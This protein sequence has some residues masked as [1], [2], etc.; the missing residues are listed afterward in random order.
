MI[1]MYVQ[2]DW[3]VSDRLT[4]NLGLRY[5]YA[6]DIMAN[7]IDWTGLRAPQFA[8]DPI[9]TGAPNQFNMLQP[10]AGFAYALNENETVVRGG[11]GLYFTGVNDVS[12]IHTEFPLS[13]LSVANPNDGRPDFPSNPWGNFPEGRQPTHEE[14]IAGSQAGLYRLDLST[15]G[16]VTLDDARVPYSH[17]F[18]LGFQQQIGDTMAFQADYVYQGGRGFRYPRNENLT[19]DAATGLNRPYSNPANRLWPDVGLVRIFDHAKTVNYHGVEM[20]F[21]KRFS[22][23]YQLSGTYTVG[24]S[25]SCSPSPVDDAFPVARDLGDD[26]W[27]TSHSDGGPADQR[28]RAVINGIWELP[29]DFQLSGLYHFGSGQRFDSFNPVDLRDT[30]GFFWPWPASAQRLMFDGSII[31]HANVEGEAIHRVDMKVMRRFNIGDVSIDGM[32]EVFNLFN[33]Q[34]YGFYQRVAILPSAGDPLPSADLA[35]WPR[36]VQLGFKVGF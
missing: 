6:H 31:D 32:V 2:D 36:M 34:N 20:G 29:Y 21:S 9:R 28:H 24:R 14:V 1:S 5:D 7:D 30:G 27:Y 13:F 25:R 17:Q 3:Q 23:G 12:A 33:H 15:Y 8:N 18:T 35:Y 26:C 10:R 19:Y 11:Y 4:L 16:P 22:Q